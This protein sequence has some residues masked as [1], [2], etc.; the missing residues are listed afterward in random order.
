MKHYNNGQELH[1]KIL[2]GVNTLADNVGSTLGPK[3]R[4][5]L[6]F[7]KE[8]GTP[9][10]TKDGVTVAKFVD[11]EDPF[12]NIGAQVVKQAAEQTATTAGDGTTTATVLSRE[13]LNK[14]QKYIIAGSSPIELKRGMDKAC[15]MLVDK[16]RENAISIR[17]ISDIEN[18]ATISANNDNTIGQL[19]STAVDAAGKDGSIV[20][21]EANSVETTLKLIEG[22]RIPSGYISNSFITNERSGTIVYENPLVMVADEK[23]EHVQDLMPTLEIAARESR[24]LLIVANEVENQALAALIMNT[25]RGT[26]KVAAVKAP[27]YGEE[28]RKIMQDLCLST[29]ATYIT[30]ANGLRVKDVK[31]SHFG[32]VNKISVNKHEST[33][34]GGKGSQDE[35]DKQIEAIKTEIQQTDSLQECERLQERITRLASGVA[36][37]RVGASTEVEMIEKK[38][39]ID[40]ALEAVRSAQ[41]EGIISGGGCALIHA[42]NG[43]IVE[44]DNDD[45]ALGAKIVIDSIEAPLRQMAKNAGESPDLIV[46]M[47]QNAP[48]TQGDVYDFMKRQI[49]PS[50]S[51]GLIDPVKVTRCAL[52]N[53]VSVSSTLITTNHAIVKQ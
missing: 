4:N 3:G 32:Q 52:Q 53:A 19:I 21:E 49:V 33:F 23:I 12:E 5:V 34:I 11:L 22:F 2:S 10:V 17:D 30:R 31:L 46:D 6:L 27:R 48:S 8:Q 50:V 47:V 1:Q 18:I 29:G 45:Q 35:I 44:T 39:R 9:V 36:V 43:L 14:A 25:A 28:R 40:D 51:S 7:H 13:M 42:S 24:P 37:I 16:L 20:I 26:M 38:H 41:E 15:T